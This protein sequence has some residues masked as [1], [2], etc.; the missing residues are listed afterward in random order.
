[1]NELTAPMWL[2]AL[3]SLIAILILVFNIQLLINL[4]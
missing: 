1:M 4:V 3:A 2:T